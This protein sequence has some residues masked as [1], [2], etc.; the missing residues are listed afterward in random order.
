MFTLVCLF[1]RF[2]LVFV[3]FLGVGVVGLLFVSTFVGFVVA[4]VLRLSVIL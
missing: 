3:L 4:A 2:V 1:R